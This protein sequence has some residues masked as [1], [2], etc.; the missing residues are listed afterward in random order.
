MQPQEKQEISVQRTAYYSTVSVLAISMI[1]PPSKEEIA[2]GE[3][4]EGG[5][6]ISKSQHKMP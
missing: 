6:V 2:R 4:E 3:V 1:S 5:E